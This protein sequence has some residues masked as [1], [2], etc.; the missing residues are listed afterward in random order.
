MPS[1]SVHVEETETLWIRFD[2]E[3]D[4]AMRRADDERLRA[5]IEDTGECIVARTGLDLHS[6]GLDVHADPSVL[7]EE[8]E[9]TTLRQE[10][11]G[12]S[13]RLRWSESSTGRSG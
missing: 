5:V 1:P 7:G 11:D 9:I 3:A 2:R 12:C 13:H 8:V 10:Q 4:D 6:S